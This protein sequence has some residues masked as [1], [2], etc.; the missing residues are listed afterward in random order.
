MALVIRVWAGQVWL[1][2]EAGEEEGKQEEE[3]CGL[4]RHVYGGVGGEGEEAEQGAGGCE[5]PV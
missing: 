2:K 3:L 1:C 5:E 4:E